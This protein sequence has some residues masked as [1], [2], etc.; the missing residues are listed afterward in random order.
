MLNYFQVSVYNVK[1]MEVFDSFQ[2]LLDDT[3]GIL[4]CVAASLKNSI[5]QLTSSH[6][7]ARTHHGWFK[8]D[9]GLDNG[10]ADLTEVV[11]HDVV[12]P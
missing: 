2:D 4:L 8:Q 10:M 11:Q 5:Q 12:I 6:P 9:N 3:A 7:K 1:L